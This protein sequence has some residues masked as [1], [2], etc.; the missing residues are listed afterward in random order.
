[1]YVILGT[2][3]ALQGALLQQTQSSPSTTTDSVQDWT[4][5]ALC[6]RSKNRLWNWESYKSNTIWNA[7]KGEELEQIQPPKESAGFEH[8][9]LCA[10]AREVPYQ[11]T[12]GKPRSSNALRANSSF[13]PWASNEVCSFWMSSNALLLYIFQ[14]DCNSAEPRLKN[15][16]VSVSKWEVALWKL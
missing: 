13:C 7:S 3:V 4:R 12:R 5:P 2:L 16:S 9:G 15:L 11:R 14:E 6:S 8:L 1:M 10:Q